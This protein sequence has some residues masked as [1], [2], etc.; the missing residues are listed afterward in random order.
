MPPSFALCPFSV[1]FFRD[2]A[3]YEVFVALWTLPDRFSVAVD[4]VNEEIRR[5]FVEPYFRGGQTTNGVHSRWRVSS[6]WFKH[7]Y[8]S[9]IP[10]TCFSFKKRWSR[11]PNDSSGKICFW[12][13]VPCALNTGQNAMCLPILD[14]R[15]RWFYFQAST[16]NRQGWVTGGICRDNNGLFLSPIYQTNR[17]VD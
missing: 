6:G 11:A 15:P 14:T 7:I 3:V 13:K 16:I 1:F 2:K 4:E 8:K 10:R 12:K 5:G 17:S 9:S